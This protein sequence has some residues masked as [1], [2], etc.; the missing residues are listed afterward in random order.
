MLL[1]VMLGFGQVSLCRGLDSVDM[2]LQRILQFS[3]CLRI[4]GRK[5]E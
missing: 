2:G 3:K 4:K 5:K 1:E